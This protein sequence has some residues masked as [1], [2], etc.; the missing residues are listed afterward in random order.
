MDVENLVGNCWD[1]RWGN[2]IWQGEVIFM[3]GVSVEWNEV[4]MRRYENVVEAVR[5]RLLKSG[6]ES[7]E[8]GG[9]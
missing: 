2:I 5:I 9:L 3:V 4:I 7:K 8:T 1:L 6:C